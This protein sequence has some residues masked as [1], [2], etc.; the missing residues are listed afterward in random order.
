MKLHHTNVDHLNQFTSYG[1]GFVKVNQQ[2]YEGSLIVGANEIREWAPASFAELAPEHFSQILELK[3]E[4]VLLGTGKTIQFPHP[5]LYAALSAA[6]IGV[7]VMDIGALCRTFN[8][9]TAEDRKVIALVL[10]R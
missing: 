10:A 8:I 4:V 9:L 7:D 6:H 1:D 5:R 2:Q 3:P